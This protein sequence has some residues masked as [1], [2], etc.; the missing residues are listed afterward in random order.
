LNCN[1]SYA[2]AGAQASNASAAHPKFL[3]RVVRIENTPARD[4]AIDMVTVRIAI[5]NAYVV[6]ADNRD[7]RW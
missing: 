2:I 3:N 7:D 6:R 4:Y 1:Q 5:G